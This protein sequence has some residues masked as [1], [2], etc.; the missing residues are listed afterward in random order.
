MQALR[1]R[2]A[3]ERQHHQAAADDADDG[4]EQA[5]AHQLQRDMRRR[6]LADRD[7]LDQHQ[8]EK[9]RER[10]VGAGFGF[11]RGADAGAQAQALGVNQ[12][13]H[14]RGIGRG[15]HGA[16]QQRLGPVQ[17]ERVFGGRRGDTAV[18]STPTV[19]STIDGASTAR[20][21]WNLVR[22]PPSNR[23]SASATDP[24]R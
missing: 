18:T 15:Y 2:H 20:M 16:D 17:I 12:Q 11:Q 8:R 5:F 6:A 21:L 7:E 14:R 10:V 1:Q 4:A 23:I 24:T 22:S 19:A 13:E 9:D 3:I